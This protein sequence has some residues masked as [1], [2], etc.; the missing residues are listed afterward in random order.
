MRALPANLQEAPA[1]YTIDDKSHSIKVLGIKWIRINDHFKFTT[2]PLAV[3]EPTKR[4]ILS[5]I[6]KL[7]D[8][9]GW[10]APA[11]IGFKLLI[12]ETWLA[13]IGWD[14]YVGLEID[15]KWNA[16]RSVFE[17]LSKITINRRILVQGTVVT[18]ELHVFCDSSEKAMQQQCIVEP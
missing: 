13:G 6:A 3:K 5:N 1:A 2:Q 4:Q 10:L 18:K 16:S 15:R 11:V 17:D 7:Y 12:Q 9:L 14:Q 8:P